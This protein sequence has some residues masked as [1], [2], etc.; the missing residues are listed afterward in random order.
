M[1]QYLPNL[2]EQTLV[3]YSEE[4]LLFFWAHSAFFRV[5]YDTRNQPATSFTEYANQ[6]RPI[7]QDEGG[8]AVGF[9]CKTAA[10][11]GDKGLQEFVA[12]GQRQIPGVP[13]YMAEEICPPVIL[14]LQIER[15]QYGISSRL[16]YAEIGLK[17]WVHANP[18][19]G[20]V[21]LQ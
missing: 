17:V 1:K 2:T 14:A 8:N 16:N 6:T 12:I 10:A 21:A 7:V 11:R 19:R 3:Q 15:D 9:V 4:S 18:K 20:L 13:E 5:A